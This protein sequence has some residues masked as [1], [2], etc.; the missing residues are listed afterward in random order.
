MRTRLKDF[1]IFT[2]QMKN[3]IPS[4]SSS[5]CVPAVAGAHDSERGEGVEGFRRWLTDITTAVS[6]SG[7]GCKGQRQCQVVGIGN[8]GARHAPGGGGRGMGSICK[9]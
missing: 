5:V 9:L 7:C 8:V 1:G 2:C 6:S 3:C 4:T